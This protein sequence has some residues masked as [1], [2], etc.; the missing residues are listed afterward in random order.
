MRALSHVGTA[1][2]RARALY[3]VVPDGSVDIVTVE[4]SREFDIKGQKKDEIFQIRGFKVGSGHVSV[5]LCSLSPI[6]IK[7]VRE[8]EGGGDQGIGNVRIRENEERTTEKWKI[9][10]LNKPLGLRCER[11]SKENL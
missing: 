11:G 1:R 5:S 7:R 10:W 4:L 8:S 2:L 9:F 6:S 3:I